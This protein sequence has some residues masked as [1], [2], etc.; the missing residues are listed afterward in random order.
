[1]A[2]LLRPLLLDEIQSWLSQ[3]E[4]CVLSLGAAAGMGKSTLLKMACDHHPQACWLPLRP[5]TPK[6]PTALQSWVE[7]MALACSLVPGGM[8]SLPR[9][10]LQ[11]ML[12]LDLSHPQPQPSRA[13][14]ER[15]MGRLVAHASAVL[16]RVMVLVVDDAADVDP[17]TLHV[18]ESL[19]S[20]Q[21]A[22]HGLRMAVALRSLDALPHQQAWRSLLKGELPVKEVVLPHFTLAESRALVA[23][24]YGVDFAR[25]ESAL[26]K[27]LHR[28]SGGTPI[29]LTELLQQLRAHGMI[30]LKS[31]GWTLTRPWPALRRNLPLGLAGL[32]GERLA[33]LQGQAPQALALFCLLRHTGQVA[34][35]WLRVLLNGAASSTPVAEHP[36]VQPLLREG[37]A[38]L[39]GTAE[40][41]ALALAHASWD[42][43]GLLPLSPSE[44]LG[45]C[46]DM[47]TRLESALPQDVL[48]H[49]HLLTW[50]STLS[51][52]E[53]DGL[54]LRASLLL[55]Q[56]AADFQLRQPS[57]LA[58]Q[59]VAARLWRCLLEL[60]APPELD[61]R[62]RLM[63]F[64]HLCS[65]GHHGEA[66]Q[67]FHTMRPELLREADRLIC[68]DLAWQLH[69]LRDLCR[70]RFQAM[71]CSP[72]LHKRLVLNEVTQTTLDGD[73]AAARTYIEQARA[74]DLS[75]DERFRVDFSH[76]MLSLQE[77]PFRQED[78]LA[79]HE[80][81]D[82][83]RAQLSRR[84]RHYLLDYLGY[85]SFNH[86][87][88]LHLPFK[89]EH[90]EV[91]KGLHW[92]SSTEQEG[93]ELSNLLLLYGAEEEMISLYLGLLPA[94]IHAPRRRL[95]YSICNLAQAMNSARRTDLTYS[96]LSLC[97]DGRS[98]GQ[99]D[100]DLLLEAERA[101]CAAIAGHEDEARQRLAALPLEEMSAAPPFGVH[102]ARIT[103]VSAVLLR[104]RELA[105]RVG[106]AGVLQD[107]TAC[108]DLLMAWCTG[109][110]APATL[111]KGAV[112]THH[113][114]P[115]FYG[116]AL[117]EI[118]VR[119]GRAQLLEPFHKL[120]A[121][122]WNDFEGPLVKASL[123]HL[124]GD[125]ARRDEELLNCITSTMRLGL[126][127]RQRWV[128]RIFPDFSLRHALDAR[129]VE[130]A[131]LWK[132]ELFQ[133][134]WEAWPPEAPC[135]RG[136]WALW[137]DEELA[138]GLAL[139]PRAAQRSVAPA[140]AVAST[141]RPKSTSCYAATILGRPQLRCPAGKMLH[142][143][144]ASWRLLGR[145]LLQNG[146]RNRPMDRMKL[147]DEVC[148]G[149]EDAKSRQLAFSQLLRRLKRCLPQE[150]TSLLE[151]LPGQLGLAHDQLAPLDAHVFQHL[152]LAARVAWRKGQEVDAM[153][154]SREALEL[155]GG[156]LLDGVDAP[157]INPLRA[158][159]ERDF[160]WLGALLLQHAG[161]LPRHQVD[162][163]KSSI[164][165]RAPHLANVPLER[166]GL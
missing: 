91:L 75:T 107:Y 48:L 92:D 53:L 17:L 66:Q 112:D 3:R 126:P 45:L 157:W 58:V 141:V 103:L 33:R 24:Y 129:G 6:A 121:E 128:R 148:G 143:P 67:L 163:L 5:G 20:S 122:H 56:H 69:S 162:L 87:L 76:Y 90:L 89:D 139:Q 98:T 70:E 30:Q 72:E 51:Q 82:D 137:L 43:A 156:P 2:I 115:W 1:M 16:G 111:P 151:V 136:Q 140:P 9:E 25:Q 110:C 123:A 31:T 102:Y 23:L 54:F 12:E 21:P 52:Q 26:I 153:R 50:E 74:L 152:T 118:A 62:L 14:V 42:S 8:Q 166:W 93:L 4:A 149:T 165:S 29:H 39:Q 127:G 109:Y 142:I 96:V 38:K 27:G 28:R 85:L 84:T 94:Y 158:S 64:H 71:D 19:L 68:L 37:M 15:H 134:G 104:D 83:E 49:M 114:T 113:L 125:I 44:E 10:D 7:E 105:L 77:S 108:D 120:M 95:H 73:T 146:H 133:P 116:A 145:L 46:R 132:K 100:S 88:E 161:A 65:A 147:M 13:W 124:A 144:R 135:A 18:V 40:G 36:D 22:A 106:G 61:Q 99:R 159:M 101:L 32:R 154:I 41:P 138:E 160:E 150:D 55:D 35:P 63:L 60:E 59:P 57:L 86:G 34:A 80:R 130:G 47:R 119:S 79:W 155:Y 131:A 78:L 81:Y 11:A 97:L 164:V 117:C